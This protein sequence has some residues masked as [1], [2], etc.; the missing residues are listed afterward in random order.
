MSCPLTGGGGEMTLYLPGKDP[1]VADPP[2]IAY[3]YAK[4]CG[5]SAMAM[6]PIVVPHLNSS[7]DKSCTNTIYVTR[8]N[9]ILIQCPLAVHGPRP[10]LSPV[11]PL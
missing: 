8:Q 6:Y 3:K 1:I 4:S 10:S 9:N 11:D 7:E 2:P 5:H